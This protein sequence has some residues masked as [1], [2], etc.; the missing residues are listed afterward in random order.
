MS[1]GFAK[2]WYATPE[3]IRSIVKLRVM[4][5]RGSLAMAADQIQFMGRN[6]YISVSRVAAVS[7][8]RQQIPWLGVAAVSLVAIP[9]CLVLD[10]L[11]H[12]AAA[13]IVVV[14]VSPSALL[15]AISTKWVKVDYQD[16]SGASRTAY[17]ADGSEFGLRGL[18]GGTKELHR[19]IASH[20]GVES[21]GP[22]K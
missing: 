5:D 20:S 18:L 1:A 16:E 7:L 6:T 19:A 8:V 15:V 11:G 12:A 13:L 21:A 14:G 22:A 4:D 2:V 3:R 10:Y 9:V 17:F